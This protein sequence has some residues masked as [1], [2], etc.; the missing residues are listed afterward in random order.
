M[1][2]IE[3]TLY[4]VY[5]YKCDTWN[6]HHDYLFLILVKVLSNTCTKKKMI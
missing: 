6:H 4:I 3:Q 5:M 1:A 2:K